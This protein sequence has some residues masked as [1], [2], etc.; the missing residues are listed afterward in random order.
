MRHAHHSHP[1]ITLSLRV[2]PEIRDQ[3]EELAEATGR[4]KSFLASEALEYYIATQA[5]QIQ[6]T[7][8]AFKKTN[9]KN[10]KFI[11]HE[12]VVAWLNSWGSKNEKEPPK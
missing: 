5:W 3:L 4:T 11:K 8:K 6:A 1:A 9:S 12:K 7:E 10:A 2:Q